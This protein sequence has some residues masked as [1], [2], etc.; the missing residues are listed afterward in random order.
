MMD[1]LAAE[2]A[3]GVHSTERDAC[4]HTQVHSTH[5][6]TNVHTHKGTDIHTSS[7]H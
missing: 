5:T 4:T 2:A 7:P 3:T 6:G 1:G